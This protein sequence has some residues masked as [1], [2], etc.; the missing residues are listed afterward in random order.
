M[1]E[2]ALSVVVPTRDRPALLDACLQSLQGELSAA[3]ELIVVDSASKDP[4]VATTARQRGATVVRCD[5]PGVGVARNAGWRAARHDVV[6]F[7]DDDVRVAPGWGGAWRAAIAAN[8]TTAFFT[9]RIGVPP[10]QGEV[11]R[12]VAV[13]DETEAAV[14]DT[15]STGSLGHS[16]N[17]AVRRW[18]LE[19]IGGFDEQMGAGSRFRSSPE[20]DLFDRLFAAGWTGRYEPG[21][22]AWHDQWRSRR[23]LVRLDYSYGTGTGARLAKLLR[24][25]AHRA[26][27][28]AREHVW[29]NGL[30]RLA[31]AVRNRNK[32]GIVLSSARLSGT[33]A[34]F[35]RAA[36]VPV[37]SGHFAR[38]RR[39]ANND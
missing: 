29:D 27:A 12:P 18:A 8:P 31:R 11:V 21:P 26:R 2:L 15:S 10:E 13:K 16:A 39:D 4:R 7:V 28:V 22:R 3:D 36:F 38:P 6:V 34:G 5:R 24:T 33:L 37:R 25:D 32:T 1:S 35:A 17:L 30:R 9:A 20:Y 19:T 14:L 23:E